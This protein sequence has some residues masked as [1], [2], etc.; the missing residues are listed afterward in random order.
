MAR[1]KN[2]QKYQKRIVLSIVLLI[3]LIIAAWAYLAHHTIAVMQPVGPIAAG[4]KSL[5]ITAFLLMLIVVIP[6]FVLTFTFAWRYRESNKKASYQPNWDHSRV[7]EAIWWLIPS[8]LIAILAVI[9][10][11]ST[12]KYDPY[13]SLAKSQKELTIQ[14]VALDWRWLFIYPEQRVASVNKLYMPVNMPV[15]F[16][17]TADAPMNSFWI[18]Q[19]GGQIYAMPGMGTMLH[20]Q[21]D[22]TGSFYGSSANISGKGF[23]GMNFTAEA[24]PTSQFD[25]WVADARK[26]TPLTWQNYTTLSQPSKNTGVLT[27]GRPDANLY[28]AIINKYMPMHHMEGM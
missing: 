23:A 7:I 13:K 3:A 5:M 15:K 1:A 17:V 2:K 22:N 10:W 20:L 25:A 19:L 21:A 11:Q 28:G 4:E 6:V 9:T 26:Q 27:Y 14:V 24:V 8:A 18:P 16:E 12:Y